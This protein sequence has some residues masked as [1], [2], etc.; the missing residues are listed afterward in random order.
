VHRLSNILYRGGETE[1]E[2]CAA[3]PGELAIAQLNVHDGVPSTVRYERIVEW[4]RLTRPDVVGLNELNN[5]GLA[6]MEQLGKDAGLP[7]ALF[8]AAKGKSGYSLGLLSRWP[9]RL[10]R[11]V[12]AQFCHGVLHATLAMPGC[13]AEGEVATATRARD[14]HVV[15]THLTPHGVGPNI[16]EAR[17]LLAHVAASVPAGE[18]AFVMGD[19]NSLSPLD[20]PAYA[21]GRTID[22]LVGADKRSGEN[23][24]KKKFVEIGVR[25]EAAEARSLSFAAHALLLAG[26][27]VDVW[28]ATAPVGGKAAGAGAKRAWQSSVPTAL[29]VDA[30]HATAMRLD[31]IYA[32][33]ALVAAT[34]HRSAAIFTDRYSAT[35]SDHFPSLAIVCFGETTSQSRCSAGGAIGVQRHLVADWKRLNLGCHWKLGATRSWAQYEQKRWKIAKEKRGEWRAEERGF[36]PVVAPRGTSC[37]M[38]CAASAARAAIGAPAAGAPTFPPLP[39]GIDAPP[40]IVFPARA[41][42]A[43]DLNA[44]RVLDTCDRLEY[45]FPCLLGCYHSAA[46]AGMEHPAFEAIDDQSGAGRCLLHEASPRSEEKSGA[47]ASGAADAPRS[48]APP[49]PFDCNAKHPRTQRMCGCTV[50]EP[51]RVWLL[52]GQRG[53]SCAAACARA[54]GECDHSALHAAN[55]CAALRSVFPCA[56]D[57]A[58]LDSDGSDQPAFVVDATSAS[59]GKCLFTTGA[60]VQRCDASHPATQRLCPCRSPRG[61]SGVASASVVGN[62][63][64]QS[65][66]RAMERA[67][68]KNLRGKIEAPP[69]ALMWCV[70]ATPASVFGARARSFRFPLRCLTARSRSHPPPL[71]SFVRC[72]RP[73]RPTRRSPP[74]LHSATSAPMAACAGSTRI[75][76]ERRK[77]RSRSR[78]CASGTSKTTLLATC[79]SCRFRRGLAF[80]PLVRSFRIG[81]ARSK[82]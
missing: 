70:V 78:G 20:A 62:D 11:E 24:L 63:A 49:M 14:V 52:P 38:A 6:R 30:M 3:R 25:A 16:A 34:S 8:Y 36:D 59:A 56:D 27:L 57:G 69:V 50:R 35:L 60:S 64:A 77:G 42:K 53:E 41:T 68:V 10:V 17:S 76:K 1:A 33:G 39:V 80:C 9:L 79:S 46:Q 55:N 12:S 22:A 82:R 37:N 54:R 32:N 31:Y 72:F 7:H 73:S 13:A 74:P 47:A 26:G 81:R 40:F 67:R 66:V 4:I 71:P 28:A 61:F 18:A 44:I 2:W 5:W 75:S 43:C 29:H 19:F 48:A 51:E 58:C 65:F 15:L 21:A 45:F 23:A